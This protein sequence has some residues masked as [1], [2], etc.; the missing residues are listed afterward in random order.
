MMRDYLKCVLVLGCLQLVWGYKWL[1]AVESCEAGMDTVGE[2]VD[3]CTWV[4]T[5]TKIVQ[6][7]KN[8][9]EWLCMCTGKRVLKE[10]TCKAGTPAA[11]PKGFNAC[12]LDKPNALVTSQQG[13]V[14]DKGV[15]SGLA[16]QTIC[17]SHAE[18][19]NDDKFAGKDPLKRACC[20]PAKNPEGL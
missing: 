19:Q 5:S 20:V 13:Y 17:K 4:G 9:K 12:T 16:C 6:N 14:K 18:S 15:A 2:T 10:G 1:G 7:P 11:L 3:T 8:K